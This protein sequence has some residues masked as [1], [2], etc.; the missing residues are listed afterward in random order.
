MCAQLTPHLV[1][2]RNAGPDDA[3]VVADWA[4]LLD[5]AGGYFHGRAAYSQAA[6][7]YCDALAIREKALGPEHPDT[8]VSLNNL[9][10]L[11]NDQGDLVGARSLHERALAINEKARGQ[12]HKDTNRTRSHLARLLLM[13][14]QPTEALALGETALAAHDKLLGQ[15]HAWTKDSARLAGE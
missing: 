13:S 1:A 10:V 8:A 12:T 3:S 9:A 4:E 7:L 11:L 15:G 6:Q 2:R 14:G 5:R